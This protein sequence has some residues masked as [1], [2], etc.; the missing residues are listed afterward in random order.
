VARR[1]SHNAHTRPAYVLAT[2]QTGQ[3]MQ[4]VNAFESPVK[5]NGSGYAEPSVV[6]LTDHLKA[7]KSMWGLSYEL[8]KSTPPLAFP[9]LLDDAA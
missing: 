1:T 2:I 6:R 9:A 3:P 4:L 8:E 7:Q 5:A